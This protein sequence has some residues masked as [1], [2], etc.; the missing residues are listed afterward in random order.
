LQEEERKYE[1]KVDIKVL[2]YLIGEGK[3][4][5]TPKI[6]WKE[7]IVEVKMGRERSLFDDPRDWELNL[8]EDNKYRD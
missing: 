8:A 4:Q 2:G 3:N 7:N 6:V 5:D 1:T